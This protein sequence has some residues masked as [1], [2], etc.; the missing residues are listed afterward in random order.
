MTGAGPDARAATIATAGDARYLWGLFLLVASA[1]KAG[2]DVPFL[3]GTRGFSPRDSRVLA[4]L[5][6]VEQLPLDGSRR[7]LTCLKSEVMLA[8]RTPFVVWAD[9]DAFFTGDVSDML[10]PGREEE[11]HFRL[12]APDEMPSA[13]PP[14]R[15]GG[16]GRAVPPAVLDAWRADVRAVA[17]SAR[18]A[19]RYA[20]TGSGC[21]LALS[22][23][24]H[25]P[26]L[27]IWDALQKRVLPDRDVGVVD[28]SLAHYHQ[29]DESTLNACLQFVPDAPRVQD[30]FR[31]DKDRERLFVHFIARPK[32]W[33]GWTR[34]A[35]RFFGAYVSVVEWAEASGLELPGPLP[36]CLRRPFERRAR[37]LAPWTELRPKLARRLGAAFPVRPRPQ[38]GGSP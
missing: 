20:T 4:G 9:S 33:E 21:F 25:R 17:G 11:I 10:L 19:P 15:F 6:G 28:R 23:A 35:L 38:K 18:E 37:L 13:F 29:L 30:V 8:A 14:R 2:M 12:R 5:G 3:V 27:E 16:D 1:R 32:P 31:M 22:L 34:R 7:S 24:R 36:P 26:F